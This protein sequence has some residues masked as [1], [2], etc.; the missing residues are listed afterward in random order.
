MVAFKDE[1]LHGYIYSFDE[2][3][4]WGFPH[5]TFIKTSG[6]E[7]LHF[8]QS[9]NFHE[10][11]YFADYTFIHQ[12]HSNCFKV[13]FNHYNLAQAARQNKIRDF[14]HLIKSKET[15]IWNCTLELNPKA[16]LEGLLKDLSELKEN[17]LKHLRKL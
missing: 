6:T 9:K 7:D 3:V 5:K 11:S 2:I 16:K 17:L 10:K 8:I 13:E 12:A 1:I 4:Q 15:E 14:E